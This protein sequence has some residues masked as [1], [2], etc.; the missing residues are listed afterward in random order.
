ML[1]S[2]KYELCQRFQIWMIKVVPKMTPYFFAVLRLNRSP[3]VPIS[4]SIH[5]YF[6]NDNLGNTDKDSIILIYILFF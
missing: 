2:L 1:S 6:Q 5:T 3:P 4:E